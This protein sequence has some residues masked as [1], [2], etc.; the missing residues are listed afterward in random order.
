[1]GGAGQCYK[2]VWSVLLGPC[3]WGVQAETCEPK[4]V[5]QQILPALVALGADPVAEVKMATIATS[6]RILRHF[7]DDAVSRVHT[8]T[9]VL[10][11]HGVGISVTHSLRFSV[12]HFVTQ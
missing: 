10:R 7:K 4:R 3:V 11:A 6:G 2:E 8:L 5:S 12:I 9:P 1:M